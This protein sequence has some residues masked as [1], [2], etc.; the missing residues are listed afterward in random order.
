LSAELEGRITLFRG[1]V[2][3]MDRWRYT[4]D[5]CDEFWA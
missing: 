2:W 5:G 1:G 3:M 4:R